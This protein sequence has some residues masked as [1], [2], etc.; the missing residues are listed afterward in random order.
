[1]RQD[2]TAAGSHSSAAVR[3]GVAGGEPLTARKRRSSSAW[4]C[5]PSPAAVRAS[6]S[7]LARL[8]GLAE[9]LIPAS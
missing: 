4:T 1:M 7:S 5:P 3:P 6:S 8:A 9:V 2:L